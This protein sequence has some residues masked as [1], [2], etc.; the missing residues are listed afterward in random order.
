MKTNLKGLE[1]NGIMS[2]KI[3]SDNHSAVI[4]DFLD[5]LGKTGNSAAKLQNFTGTHSYQTIMGD[6][7]KNFMA[8]QPVADLQAGSPIVTLLETMAHS[9]FQFQQEVV[10]M[11][12]DLTLPPRKGP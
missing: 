11:I 12:K 3:G 4:Y 1:R 2:S 8:A 10:E 9:Q 5:V 7:V 6:M